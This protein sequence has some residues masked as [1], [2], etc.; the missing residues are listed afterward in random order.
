[1]VSGSGD[2]APYGERKLT[3]REFERHV[4]H[5]PAND[6][7][8]AAVDPEQLADGLSCRRELTQMVYPELPL[9]SSRA[10]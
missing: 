2:L 10:N 3:R 9:T 8:L 1:M 4:G 5:L 6:W 7:G